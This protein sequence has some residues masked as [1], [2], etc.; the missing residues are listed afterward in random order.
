M[1]VCEVEGYLQSLPGRLWDQQLRAIQ[2]RLTTPAHAE[3]VIELPHIK[4]DAQPLF[5]GD[6][7]EYPALMNGWCAH[8]ASLFPGARG[9][10]S[11]ER[12]EYEAI[13]ASTMRPLTQPIRKLDAF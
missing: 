10:N 11:E 1:V 12:A 13:N 5:I 8:A 4:E 9:M 7:A 2:I 3:R 6:T